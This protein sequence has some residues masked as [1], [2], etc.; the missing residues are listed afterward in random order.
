M[1]TVQSADKEPAS[2]ML[3]ISTF[4]PNCYNKNLLKPLFTI[5]SKIFKIIILLIM[6]LDLKLK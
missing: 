3:F 2:E 4:I 6:S 1:R 5:F